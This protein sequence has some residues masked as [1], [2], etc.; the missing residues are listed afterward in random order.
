M[1]INLL[2]WREEILAY[3]KKIFS[4][5]ILFS[6]I[7]SVIF[8]VIAYQFFFAQVSYTEKYMNALNAA[9]QNLVGSVSAFVNQKK[10]QDEIATRYA[11]L[12]KLNQS[13][14]DAV[15]M[16]DGLAKITP[17]GIYITK[18]ARKNNNIEISGVANSNLVI[19]EFL[20]AINKSPHLDVVSLDKVEKKEGEKIIETRFDLKAV[21]TLGQHIDQPNDPTVKP[22]GK[23][24]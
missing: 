22:A 23:T 6:L 19:A 10:I 2:P 5:L 9:K 17:V 7:L 18:L 11:T 4:W 14:Y 3:N 15:L 12:E 16:M 20:D 21:L 13:R 1:D 24:S 8:L